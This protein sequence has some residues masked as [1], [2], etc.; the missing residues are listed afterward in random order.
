MAKNVGREYAAMTEDERR[1]FELKRR[2]KA[3]DGARSDD[4]RN[5]ELDL[6]DPRS[7]REDDLRREG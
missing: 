2:G 6:D 4:T 5:E 1:E 3:G 7:Y